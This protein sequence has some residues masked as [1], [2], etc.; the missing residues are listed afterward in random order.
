MGLRPVLLGILLNLCAES[1]RAD[2]T[3]PVDVHETAVAECFA[4]LT[5]REAAALLGIL[6][7][8]RIMP[9]KGDGG[10]VEALSFDSAVALVARVTGFPREQL[11]GLYRDH[12]IDLRRTTA[13]RLIALLAGHPHVQRLLRIFELE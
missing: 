7:E 4:Q 2:P 6:Q 13:P 10:W 3:C 8:Y 5:P 9:A 11:Q 1:P 12:W